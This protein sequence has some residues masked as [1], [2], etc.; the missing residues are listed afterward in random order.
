[1]GEVKISQEIPSVLQNWTRALQIYRNCLVFIHDIPN[2]CDVFRSNRCS[3]VN[4]ANRSKMKPKIG[5]CQ[6][7]LMKMLIQFGKCRLLQFKSRWM[8]RSSE[9]DCLALNIQFTISLAPC[10]LFRSSSSSITGSLKIVSAH[11][12]RK[13]RPTIDTMKSSA[14]ISWNGKLILH[15][16]ILIFSSSFSVDALWE[17]GKQTED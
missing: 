10:W 14:F 16:M 3:F 15:N 4:L 1:M 17:G 12:A 13:C 7:S 8:P 6:R 11:N 2:K 9:N 5:V